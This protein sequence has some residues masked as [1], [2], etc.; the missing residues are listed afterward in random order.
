VF[1]AGWKEDMNEAEAIE[2]YT[3]TFARLLLVSKDYRLFAPL[4]YIF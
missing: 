1:E 2:V 4:Q 3:H